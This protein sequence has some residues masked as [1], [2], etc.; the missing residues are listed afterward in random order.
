MNHLSALQP[1]GFERLR[2]KLNTDTVGRDFEPLQV[3]SGPLKRAKNVDII[4]FLNIDRF[5]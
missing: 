4:T 2:Q 3:K 5:K 1:Q